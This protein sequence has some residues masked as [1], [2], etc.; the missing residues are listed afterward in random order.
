MHTV[1]FSVVAHCVTGPC[2]NALCVFKSHQQMEEILHRG[3]RLIEMKKRKIQKAV[4]GDKQSTFP[5]RQTC[6]CRSEQ[7][8]KGVCMEERTLNLYQRSVIKAKYIYPH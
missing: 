2:R 1:G 4:C 7:A 6:W 3:R 8:V 5:L